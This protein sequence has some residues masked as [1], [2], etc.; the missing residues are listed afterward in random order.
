MKALILILGGALAIVAIS[1]VSTRPTTYS[2]QCGPLYFES[3]ELTFTMSG[4]VKSIEKGGKKVN[5]SNVPCMY[6]E[7]E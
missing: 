2:G 3:A 4:L 7:D 5:I 6:R 1:L